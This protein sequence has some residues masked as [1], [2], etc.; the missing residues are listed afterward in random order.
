MD[1]KEY[2]SRLANFLVA[3]NTTMVRADL[4]KHLIWNGFITNEGYVGGKRGTY[5]V[6]YETYDWLVSVGKQVEA[7]NIKLAFK[8]SDG[9]SAYDV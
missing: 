4:I 3:N 1:K 8:K 6:I 5:V 2:I 9:E 7:D